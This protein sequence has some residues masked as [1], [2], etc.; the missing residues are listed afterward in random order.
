MSCLDQAPRRGEGD[1][2]RQRM[3]WREQSGQQL[4][5]GWNVSFEERKEPRTEGAKVSGPTNQENG[6]ATERE[7]PH[8]VEGIQPAVRTLSVREAQPVCPTGAQG[9][10]G[11]KCGSH[12][13]RGRDDSNEEMCRPNNIHAVMETVMEPNAVNSRLLMS[14]E[15]RPEANPRV[16]VQRGQTAAMWPPLKVGFMS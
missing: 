9:L 8:G 14:R 16:K 6:D 11:Y 10:A 2:V 13:D 5:T 4:T 15:E 3:F 1:A 7:Q 12:Q